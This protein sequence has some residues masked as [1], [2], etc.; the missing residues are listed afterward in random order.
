MSGTAT[1]ITVPDT[2][3]TNSA[4]ILQNLLNVPDKSTEPQIL[5]GLV[6][7]PESIHDRSD[8]VVRDNR[9][10]GIV[11]LRPCMVTVM[12]TSVNATSSLNVK[13][14]SEASL[15]QILKQSDDLIAVSLVV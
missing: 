12:G 7:L 9:Q 3:I 8:L 4:E 6:L 2:K 1:A 13:P 11:L 10:N 15:A 5:V 14:L